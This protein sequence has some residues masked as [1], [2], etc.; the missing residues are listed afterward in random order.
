MDII[1]NGLVVGG[2]EAAL[3][4]A[5]KAAERAVSTHHSVVVTAVVAAADCVVMLRDFIDA[6]AGPN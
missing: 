3:R 2:P 5:Y 6:L 1:E 4:L